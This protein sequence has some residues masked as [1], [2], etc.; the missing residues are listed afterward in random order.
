MLQINPIPYGDARVSTGGQ[1]LA[2]QDAALH[3]A[4]CIKVFAEKASGRKT[5]RAGEMEL[6][7]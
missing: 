4:G 3:A 6:V 1:T 5:D 2:A 7:G